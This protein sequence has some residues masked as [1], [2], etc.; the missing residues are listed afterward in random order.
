[1]KE[2]VDRQTDRWAGKQ[3]GKTG[4]PP[5]RMK[6]RQTDKKV[7]APGRQTGNGL[8]KAL[9]EWEIDGGQT[10]VSNIGFPMLHLPLFVSSLQQSVCLAVMKNTASVINL[11][12]ASK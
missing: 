11:E 6:D 4:R 12:S 3:I 5:D 1:M 7:R 10:H 8:K 2:P 9:C